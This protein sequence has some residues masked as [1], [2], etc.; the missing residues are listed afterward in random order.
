MSTTTQ[1]PTAQEQLLQAVAGGA[2]VNNESRKLL[3]K[4]GLWGVANSINQNH[5]LSAALVQKQFGAGGVSPDQISKLMDTVPFGGTVSITNIGTQPSE[6]PSQPS[7]PAPP[8]PG[9]VGDGIRFPPTQPAPI[10]QR[11][12]DSVAPTPASSSFSKLLAT[13]LLAGLAGAAGVGIPAA[14]LMNRP[15][16]KPNPGIN[17]ELELEIPFNVKRRS[18]HR[19]TTDTSKS[20]T[21]SDTK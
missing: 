13:G 3:H 20:S 4:L 17:G 6:A 15:A 12:T 10:T 11:P 18:E 9:A 14:F 8:P 7:S 19:T 2:E 21:K 5:G 1:T 16:Q